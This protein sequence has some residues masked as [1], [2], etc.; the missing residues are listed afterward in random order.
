MRV[1]RTAD[2]KENLCDTCFKRSEIPICTSVDV[3]FG[4]GI[5]NDNVIACSNC[6]SKYSETIYPAEICKIVRNE[7]NK[8]D[9]T[10]DRSSADYR[11]VFNKGYKKDYDQAIKDF[12][13]YENELKAGK[14]LT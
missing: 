8:E 9:L 13:K 10:M 5:G 7:Q 11:E 4:N 2:T 3:E 6:L 1:I 12:Q 14:K